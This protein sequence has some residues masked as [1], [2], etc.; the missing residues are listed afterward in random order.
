[1]LLGHYA[2]EELLGRGGIGRVYAARRE[3]DGHPVAVKL[4]LLTQVPDWSVRDLFER[5]T[6]VL[7][8]LAH[9]GLPAVHDFAQDEAGRL[10][11][12][13][14]RFDG[15]TLE[16]RVR[17]DHRHISGET[18]R[19]LAESLLRLLEYLHGRV[20]PVLHR[21][22]KPSNIM[23]RTAA[24][25]DPVLVDFDT[26]AP[27]NRTGLTIV[28]TPGYSAPEQFYGEA[29][30]ASDLYSLG[31]TL[32]FVATQTD[33]GDL[34]R[35]AGRFDVERRLGNLDPA[36]RK[37]LMRMVEPAPARRC[38]SATEALADLSRPVVRAP[39]PSDEVARARRRLLAVTGGVLLAVAIAIALLLLYPMAPVSSPPRVLPAAPREAVS[40]APP[41]VA[42]PA[43]AAAPATPAPAPVLFPGGATAKVRL[44]SSPE[45]AQ[46]S[47][48]GRRLGK[49]PV[50]TRLPLGI[51]EVRFERDGRAL[52]RRLHVIEDVDLQVSF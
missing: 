22:I 14:E 27:P 21:D 40:S 41:R 12:V 16:S 52:E 10:V 49:T 1:V 34:P 20:P 43:P 25:W 15:G 45:G 13:R 47:V 50:R 7:Q 42:P 8:G 29:S 51:H 48:N 33:A 2:L 30:P 31:A 6:R 28:G 19:H 17:A 9:P 4:L 44:G 3:P 23:F 37:V 5:S 36:L 26:V 32:L 46:V 38:A 18:F 24:D 35:R 11:L 39:R